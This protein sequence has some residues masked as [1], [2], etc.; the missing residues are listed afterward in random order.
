MNRRNTQSK[1]TI[2]TVHSRVANAIDLRTW[3]TCG[4]AVRS[5]VGAGLD[6]E[7]IPGP[8]TSPPTSRGAL[9]PVT[10]PHPPARDAA[11]R[12]A[13]LRKDQA[14]DRG[15]RGR[16]RATRT[17]ASHARAA[18]SA[19]PESRVALAVPEEEPV[20]PRGSRTRRAT[21]RSA[22]GPRS[23]GPAAAT[24][25]E[26]GVV[27]RVESGRPRATARRRR[28]GRRDDDQRERDQPRRPPSRGGS[29]SAA[30]RRPT[31]LGQARQVEAE[32]E[33]EQDA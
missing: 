24:A 10:S 22:S 27:V 8:G 21:I 31:S 30:G 14:T 11:Q 20:T 25:S 13:R 29:P 32:P 1:N 7:S 6:R 2:A 33:R 12:M 28:G 5:V 19:E 18:R 3:P 4:R 15:A 9:R 16:G 17:S 26:P 23:S